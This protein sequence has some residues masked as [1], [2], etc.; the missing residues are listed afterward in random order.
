MSLVHAAMPDRYGVIGNPVAH[1]L[2]PVIHAA[3]ARQ[4]GDA[5][6]YARILAPLDGFVATIC[7]FF[8]AGGRGLNV[9]L[10]FKLEAF[11]WCGEQVSAR[12]RRAGAVNVLA[13]RGDAVHGD[14]TDGIGLATDLLRIARSTGLSIEGARV[15]LIGA[16]GAARGV[17]EP[18]LAMGPER[19]AIANRDVAK[20]DELVRMFAHDASTRIDAISLA[21]AGADGFDIVIHATSAGL[22]NAA[23]ALPQGLFKGTRIAYDMTYGAAPTPFMR[24]AHEGGAAVVSDGL[25]MLVEQA[26]E[27]FAIWRGHRP[28]AAPVLASLR[29]SLNASLNTPR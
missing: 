7:A 15:L 28:D 23:P 14:N 24:L 2:S 6:D 26:A 5:I 10:P 3:F 21:D 11:A 29:Q 8:D 22:A 9:T 18:L 16:G 12:A 4:A 1:S 25:G 19:L 13:M 17:V 20:A 27:S